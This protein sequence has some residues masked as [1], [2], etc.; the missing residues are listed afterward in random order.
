MR[1][2]VGLDAH[3]AVLA[4]ALAAVGE[5]PRSS[6]MKLWMISGLKT[7]SSKLPLMPADVDGRRRCP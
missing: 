3:H 4:E 6:C 1:S 7:L 2:A 5:E